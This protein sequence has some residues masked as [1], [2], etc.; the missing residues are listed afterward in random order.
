[1]VIESCEEREENGE[2]RNFCLTKQATRV[3]KI[4]F[5]TVAKMRQSVHEL[6]VKFPLP[7]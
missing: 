4:G 7:Y 3:R 2:K 6:T 1:M 5:D